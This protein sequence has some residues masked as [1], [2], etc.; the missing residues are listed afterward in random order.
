MAIYASLLP[1]PMV[2]ERKC[3]CWAINYIE[4]GE[5]KKIVKQE[6]N[7]FA[8]ISE[9]IIFSALFLIYFRSRV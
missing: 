7:I 3:M 6:K 9:Q 5:R 1:K 8:E 2:K 4:W